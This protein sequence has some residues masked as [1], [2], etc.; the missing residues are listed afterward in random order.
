MIN[1]DSTKEDSERR[2][3]ER[4]EFL[5]S[6]RVIIDTVDDKQEI[7][8]IDVKGD[9]KDLSL[10][11]VFI[12]TQEKVPTGSPCSVSIFL[13]GTKEDIKI[14]IQGVVARIENTGLGIAFDSMDVDSFAHLKS[15]V[16]YNS[17]NN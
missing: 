1:R 12:I 5:T 10:K 13:S 6:I 7:K 3:H 15:I 4:V 2:K 11:G 16:K 9:S 14:Q 8:K 17:G